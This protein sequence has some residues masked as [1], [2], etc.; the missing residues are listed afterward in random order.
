MS[1]D[2]K[3]KIFKE[4]ELTYK[5]K[6][7]QKAKEKRQKDQMS[8]TIFGLIVYSIALIGVVVLSYVGFK[9]VINNLKEKQAVVEEAEKKALEEEDKKNKEEKW[10]EN[11]SLADAMSRLNERESHIIELRFF[12]GKTQ[13]EVAEEIHISQAQVSR[14]EKSALKNMKN[15]LGN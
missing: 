15:Y 10:V 11:L 2:L 1:E 7:R 5:E 6:R 12:E 8:V 4:K 13:M 9:S 3:S 14:L